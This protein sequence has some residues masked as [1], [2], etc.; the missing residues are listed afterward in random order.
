MFARSILRSVIVFAVPSAVVSSQI[1]A[2]YRVESKDAPIVLGRGY[3]VSN[4][5]IMGLCMDVDLENDITVPSFDYEYILRDISTHDLVTSDETLKTTKSYLDATARVESATRVTTTK[6]DTTT[7]TVMSLMLV[8]KYYISAD[9]TNLALSEDALSLINTGNFLLFFQSCGPTMIRSVR[10]AS[11]FA[12]YFSST[13]TKS[14]S[15]TTVNYLNTLGSSSIY[16][17]GGNVKSS[18]TDMT[19]EMKIYGIT[20]KGEKAN[21][22]FNARNFDE[23][24]VAMDAAFEAMMDPAVG[25]VKSIEVVPWINNL[26]FQ[27]AVQMDTPIIAASSTTH[28]FM[29]RFYTIVNAEHLARVDS[30]LSQRIRVISNIV[31]CLSAV[32]GFSRTDNDKM[33]QNKWHICVP[34]MACPNLTVLGLKEALTSKRDLVTDEEHHRRYLLGRTVDNLRGYITNYVAPCFDDLTREAHGVP[35][36]NMQTLH[37]ANMDGCRETSCIFSGTKWETDKCVATDT[38]D[39]VDLIIEQYCMPAIL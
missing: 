26:Q 25:I 29:R 5:Q 19:I 37:W 23:Y 18:A 14:E 12:G 35:G 22:A 13:T 4:G 21:R 31:S 38:S 1:I 33:L 17:N 28:S 7:N 27:A 15:T 2:D 8:D 11:E 20:L 9:E 34:G 16:G 32:M 6:D 3:S 30:I 39:N 24:M 36:G 10:R